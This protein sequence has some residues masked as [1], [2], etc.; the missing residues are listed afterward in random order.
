MKGERNLIKAILAVL[1]SE[2]SLTICRLNHFPI[3]INV[4]LAKGSQ[5]KSKGMG[6]LSNGDVETARIVLIS[7][8]SWA[9]LT[10]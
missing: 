7:K 9:Q 3:T 4:M 5:V 10:V 6:T 2:N 1:L 8:A